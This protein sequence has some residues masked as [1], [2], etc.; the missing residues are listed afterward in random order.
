MNL[1]ERDFL[2]ALSARSVPVPDLEVEIDGLPLGPSWPDRKV[3]VGVDLTDDEQRLLVDL[4]W[5]VVDMD[6]DAVE[7]ALAGGTA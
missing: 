5:Q 6:I 4:G 1:P 2:V 3:T 7:T